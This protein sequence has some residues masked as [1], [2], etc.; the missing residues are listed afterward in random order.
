MGTELYW[1][2]TEETR[3]TTKFRHLI[4]LLAQKLSSLGGGTRPSIE[5]TLT[6]L[7]LLP[8]SGTRNSKITDRFSP[9]TYRAIAESS[10]FERFLRSLW[11]HLPQ[12]PNRYRIK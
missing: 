10:I 1:R 3:V 2:E 8:W 6:R 11:Y 12:Y 4:F 5:K 9:L 7:H